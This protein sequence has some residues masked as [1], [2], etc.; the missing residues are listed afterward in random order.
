MAGWNVLPPE[1]RILV[2]EMVGQH[3][4][5]QGRK[6]SCAAVSKEWQAFFEEKNFRRLTLSQR[7]L[8]NFVEIVRPN[9]RK[10]VEHIWLQIE[11]GA[12][13]CRSCHPP[14]DESESARNNRFFTTTL[15]VLLTALSTWEMNGPFG[16]GDKGPILELRV[17]TAADWNHFFPLSGVN[18][19]TYPRLSDQDCTD[20]EYF[21]HLLLAY[22]T[23]L[24]QSA[25]NTDPNNSLAN[26][27]QSCAAA[28]G[29]RLRGFGKP[30][31]L[32]FNC[33]TTGA[34]R[35][36][37]DVDIVKG[38]LIR[39]QSRRAIHISAIREI[40][41]RL[42]GVEHIAYEPWRHLH[43]QQSIV[44]DGGMSDVVFPVLYG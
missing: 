32:N 31:Q 1:I 16:L 6:G 39:R 10:L 14:E 21:V 11:V 9:R 41:K 30:L 27:T 36:F 22:L 29:R 38:F 23:R 17:N 15:S 8:D 4:D 3:K 37:P 26:G 35:D 13:S 42:P 19:N 44:R 25:G 40:L 12:Y 18:T 2:L 34:A 43:W 5:G 28:P 20:E 7:C 33:P 24:C